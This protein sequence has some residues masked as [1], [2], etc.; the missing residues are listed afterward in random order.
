MNS[1]DK[2]EEYLYLGNRY[3]LESYEKFALIVN[4]TKENDVK[5]PPKCRQCIRIPIDDNP[6]VDACCAELIPAVTFCNK[7]FIIYNILI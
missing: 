5:I 4:C 7:L 3:A 6:D 2:I 1:Y